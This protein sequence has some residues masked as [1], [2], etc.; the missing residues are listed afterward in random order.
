MT[1]V[2]VTEI[3]EAMR[4]LQSTKTRLIDIR[5]ARSSNNFITCFLFFFF[6]FLEIYVQQVVYVLRRTGSDKLPLGVIML[7]ESSRS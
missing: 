3:G 6:C 4:V 5:T 7:I 1:V 2:L